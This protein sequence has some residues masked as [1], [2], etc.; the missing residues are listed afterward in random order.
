[1][2]N[3]QYSSN[4]Q[5]VQAHGL[6][7]FLAVVPSASD[8]MATQPHSVA[9]SF[10]SV[11]RV[12]VVDGDAAMT[13]KRMAF[14][15]APGDCVM[16]A[17]NNDSLYRQWREHEVFRNT[18]QGSVWRVPKSDQAADMALAFLV[19]KIVG[20]HPSLNQAQWVFFARDKSFLALQSLL[21]LEGVADHNIV[22]FDIA[23]VKC[24]KEEATAHDFGA[25]PPATSP[26]RKSA[27]QAP[28]ATSP[29]TT[30]KTPVKGLSRLA[31]ELFSLAAQTHDSHRLT[32]SAFAA[33]I[34]DHVKR[35]GKDR[36]RLL[37]SITHHAI[38]Q[39]ITTKTIMA[40]IDRQQYK[41][42]GGRIFL[43]AKQ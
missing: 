32:M 36:E 17:T 9:Q 13:P 18:C 24:C 33:W 27:R 42:E 22:Q 29:A 35:H 19:G 38:G 21:V 41:R 30:K 10:D 28:I 25:Q 20:Q 4:E 34:H 12:L 26:S 40:W 14:M 43:P 37:N 5:A 7:P 1:M 6:T 23:E 39:R 15:V 8:S 31:I 16:V 11:R 2:A 3:A